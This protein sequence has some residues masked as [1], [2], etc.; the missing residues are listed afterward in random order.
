MK[1]RYIYMKFLGL[2]L[3]L[4]G[5][6]YSITSFNN[7]FSYIFKTR[8]FSENINLFLII[9]CLM[10]PLYIFVYGV[11]FY[12]YTDFNIQKIN[13]FIFITNIIFLIIGVAM[14][15]FNQLSFLKYSFM[16][17][18]FEF[19]HVSLAYCLIFLSFMG[20]YGCFKYKY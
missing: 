6:S 4:I 18:I 19:L 16:V 3:V 9:I 15:L 13:K 5:F 10:I 12:F 8:I 17:Q 14:I 11:Y 7:F 2:L 20:I 1:I